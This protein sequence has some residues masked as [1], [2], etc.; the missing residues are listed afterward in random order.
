MFCFS[1]QNI[2]N[3][4]YFKIRYLMPTEFYLKST[5]KGKHLIFFKKTSFSVWFYVGTIFTI[6]EEK[7]RTIQKTLK[8]TQKQGKHLQTQNRDKGNRIKK[9]N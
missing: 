5:S 3:I 4:F 2:N 9:N 6:I 8:K 1:T 7:H